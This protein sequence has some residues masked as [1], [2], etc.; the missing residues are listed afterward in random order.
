[1][2]PFRRLPIDHSSPAIS[3]ISVATPL[4]DLVLSS[5]AA[6]SLSKTLNEKVAI[7]RAHVFLEGRI[8]ELIK[9]MDNREKE[10]STLKLSEFTR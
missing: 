5:K 8:N 7:E 6:S 4:E 1:M 3:D 2:G 10:Y 9:S